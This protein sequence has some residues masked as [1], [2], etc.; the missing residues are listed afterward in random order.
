MHPVR[1][2]PTIAAAL[3]AA[4]LALAC[5]GCGSSGATGTST[6]ASAAAGGATKAQFIAHA[7]RICAA[8][9]AE[10]KP[11]EARQ[12]ALKGL[13]A[14]TADR[15]FVSLVHQLVIYSHTAASKLQLLPRPTAD[16]PSIDKLLTALSLESHEA[17]GIADAASRQEAN[18]GEADQQALRRSI[19]NNRALAAQYGMK[20]CIGGE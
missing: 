14:A 13:P 12:Q 19:A 15:Q 9:S 5:A 1:R 7:E 20:D 3:P 6:N 2:L 10:E 18:T 4:L 8:L 17:N 16:A 11:L